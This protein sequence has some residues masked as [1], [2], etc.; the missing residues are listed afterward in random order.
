MPIITQRCSPEVHRLLGK[1]IR[2]V[3]NDFDGYGEVIEV[4]GFKTPD[5]EYHDAFIKL[6][7]DD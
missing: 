4:Q 5:G 2:V 1:R 6:E 7:S 3:T